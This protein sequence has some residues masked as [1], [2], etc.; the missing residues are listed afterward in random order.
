MTQKDEENAM[1]FTEAVHPNPASSNISEIN[2]PDGKKQIPGDA[3]AQ[4][5]RLG[6]EGKRELPTF[7]R[8]QSVFSLKCRNDWLALISLS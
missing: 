6:K 4:N 3:S 7:L 2:G 8:G 1:R 5:A